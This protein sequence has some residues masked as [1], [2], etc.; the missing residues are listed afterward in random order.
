M[1]FQTEFKIQRNKSSLFLGLGSFVFVTDGRRW[2]GHSPREE[3]AAPAQSQVSSPVPSHS[4]RYSSRGKELCLPVDIPVVV[5]CLRVTGLCWLQPPILIWVLHS[6]MTVL[7]L[8]SAALF[9]SWKTI[10]LLGR[11]WPMGPR[12][13]RGLHP[14]TSCCFMEHVLMCTV[15]SGVLYLEYPFLVESLQSPYYNFKKTEFSEQKVPM[16]KDCLPFPWL[17]S[18]R[19]MPMCQQK[20][21]FLLLSSIIYWHSQLSPSWWLLLQL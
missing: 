7:W 2:G 20:E 10:P 4:L 6:S 8:F 19:W 18:Q 15:D 17:H 3:E 5:L 21:I 9:Y 14:K 1:A 11:S 12:S 16:T 13:W